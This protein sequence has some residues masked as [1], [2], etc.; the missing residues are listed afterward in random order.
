MKKYKILLDSTEYIIYDYG[1]FG[2][3]II[4]YFIKGLISGFNY[5]P[6]EMLLNEH[7]KDFK[8]RF[9]SKNLLIEFNGKVDIFPKD[10]EI[11]TDLE[12]SI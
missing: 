11:P 3:D 4:K 8:E 5:E 7:N 10:I 2:K 6:E 9:L 12:I 1:E